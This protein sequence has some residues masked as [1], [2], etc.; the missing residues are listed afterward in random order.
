[1]KKLMV[2][3]VVLVAGCVPSDVQMQDL[4]ESVDV[5]MAEIDGQ[6]AKLGREIDRVQGQVV[7]VNDAMKTA[8]DVHGKIAAGIEASAPFNPYADEMSAVLALV[9]AGAGIFA[10][11]AGT[12]AE[13]EKTK[14]KAER[15]GRELTLRQLA[16]MKKEDVGAEKVKALMYEN[17]GAARAV[18]RV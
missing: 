14:R 5:L 13:R 2:V 4:G 15:A 9:A 1:M 18:R 11:R 8:G 6:Q 10:K 16:D 7:L 12:Q 3:L 17:I